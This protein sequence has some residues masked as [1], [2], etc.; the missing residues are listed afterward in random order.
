MFLTAAIGCYGETSTMRIVDVSA[1]GAKIDGRQIGSA[2]E[3]IEFRR[4]EVAVR[5]RLV[6]AECQ[7]S[8]V[9]FEAPIEISA[10]LRHVSEPRRRPSPAA[11]RPPVTTTRL[12]RAERENL[13]WLINCLG[14]AQ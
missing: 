5:G 12:T 6:W 14:V 9:E 7:R 8:G 3:W 13:D 1:T 4:N 11:W 2:G 10:L